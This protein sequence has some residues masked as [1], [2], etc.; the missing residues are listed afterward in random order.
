MERSPEHYNNFD[1]VR[2]SAALAVLCS[3]QLA[4]SMHPEPRPFGLMT[5]GT[6]AVLVFFSL[7]GYLVMQSWERDPDWRRFLVKR[8]LRIWPGLAVVTLLAVLLIGPLMSTLSL[9]D[10]FAEGLT[11][12]Y[13]KQLYL[14]IQFR[15]P[16]LFT[17][18]A[19]PVVNGSLWTIPIE[20]RWYLMLLLAG[21]LGL[22][23]PARRGWAA[24]ALLAYAVYLYGIFDVQHNPRAMFMQPDFGCEYGSF[25]CYGA[26]LYLWRDVWR[27]RR[28]LT[29]L[30]LAALAAVLATCGYGYA[31]L[32]V[33]LP[34]VVLCIGTAAT[35]VLRRAG[36]F[37]DLSYG[38]YIYAYLMQQVVLALTGPKLS[39]LGGL[40]ISGSVT[41]CCALLS[42]HLVEKPAL[43]WK[44]RAPL[45]VPRSE[46]SRLAGG[47][48]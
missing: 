35:P 14:D 40:A 15:L 2:L 46:W 1:F 26:M 22:L 21:V 7:S 3:H 45:P 10:Y 30:V 25:F 44:P 23:R 20:A 27:P 16:G 29:A 32:F 9:R 38:I 18:N 48:A 6:L 4:L 36:R 13:L 12:T 33:L 24:L 34:F 5:L 43:R 31:A 19:W 28:A 39:Y 42:W 41:L 11:W 47:E 8:A 37:G 17:H